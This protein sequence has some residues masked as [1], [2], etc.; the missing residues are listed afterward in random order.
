MINDEAEA[1]MN[2][3]GIIRNRLKI[4]STITNAQLFIDIQKEI[5]SFYNYTLSF[6]PCKKPITNNV[7][8]FKD[9]PVSSAE[10]DAMSND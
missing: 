8:S 10:S 9:I 4:K 5:G 2:F 7:E 1:L 6:F 3:D